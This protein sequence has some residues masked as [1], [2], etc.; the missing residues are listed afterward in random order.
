MLLKKALEDK[1]MDY[2]IRDRLVDDGKITKEDVQKFLDD[3]K[4][5]KSDVENTRIE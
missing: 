4:D 2:R 3:L 1:L 5:E